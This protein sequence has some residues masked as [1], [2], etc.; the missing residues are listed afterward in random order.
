MKTLALHT[1]L[2]TGTHTGTHTIH[3]TCS[4]ICTLA[5]ERHT[6]E[7]GLLHMRTL[8]LIWHSK[9]HVVTA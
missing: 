7:H 2:N 3:K 4:A 9:T 5:Q 1:E 8:A 6:L